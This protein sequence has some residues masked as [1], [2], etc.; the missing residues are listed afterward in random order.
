MP[1]KLENSDINTR[2]YGWGTATTVGGLSTSVVDENFTSGT[3]PMRAVRR[4]AS[5]MPFSNLV[6]PSGYSNGG[7]NILLAN[8]WAQVNRFIL[9]NSPRAT[10]TGNSSSVIPIY[11]SNTNPHGTGTL[12][13]GG[14]SSSYAVSNYCPP[15][16]MLGIQAQGGSGGEGVSLAA[17]EFMAMEYA[18]SSG[19]GG[20]GGAAMITY[21]RLPTGFNLVGYY[22]INGDVTLYDASGNILLVCSK[23]NNGEGGYIDSSGDAFVGFIKSIRQPDGGVEQSTVSYAGW[24]ANPDFIT[25]YIT[26]KSGYPSYNSTAGRAGGSGALYATVPITGGNNRY[27]VN[28]TGLS[29]AIYINGT[30]DKTLPPQS[31]GLADIGETGSGEGGGGGASRFGTGGNTRSGTGSGYGQGGGGGFP[32]YG[33]PAYL[34]YVKN[35]KAGGAGGAAC[36][37]LYW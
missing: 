16:I 30:S 21:W 2:V 20:S 11:Y 23:G 32:P 4:N 19:G 17:S 28:G 29:T 12:Y 37:Q 8:G 3:V 15:V 13:I 24:S 34:N 31:G 25:G 26:G 5:F 35:F 10:R 7:A 14:S 1:F 22:K 6:I 36:I 27:G 33:S 9:S 18:R